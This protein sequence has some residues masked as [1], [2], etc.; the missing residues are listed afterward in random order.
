MSSAKAPPKIFDEDLLVLRRQRAAKREG[1]FL[2]DRCVADAAERLLDI[3][4]NFENVLVLGSDVMARDLVSRLPPNK[5][6][7]VTTCETLEDL[8]LKL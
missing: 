4:R 1:S 2:I 3:N 6:E 8:P 7:Q 5:I